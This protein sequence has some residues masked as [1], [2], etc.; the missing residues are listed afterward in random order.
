MKH[1]VKHL[2]KTLTYPSGIQGQTQLCVTYICDGTKGGGIEHSFEGAREQNKTVLE[3]Q[4]QDLRNY[5]KLHKLMADWFYSTK[6][7][8]QLE[9]KVDDV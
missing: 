8:E 4:L 5:M 3:K 6:E 2:S 7:N 1:F 9:K